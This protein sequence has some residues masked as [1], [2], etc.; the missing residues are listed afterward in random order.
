MEGNHMEQVDDRTA[1]QRAADDVAARRKALDD[2]ENSVDK[3]AGLDGDRVAETRRLLAEGG[4]KAVEKKLGKGAAAS[5]EAAK[6]RTQRAS[7]RRHEREL[8]QRAASSDTVERGKAKAAD[9]NG[10]AT[11]LRDQAVA[12]E[13]ER[14]QREQEPASRGR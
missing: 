9:R 1:E 5:P 3:G 2:A 12:R 13:R 4:D 14:A 6:A 11:P 8:A 7:I 10:S